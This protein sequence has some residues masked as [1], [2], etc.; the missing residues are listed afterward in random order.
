MMQT[1]LR[2]A[3]L[4]TATAFGAGCSTLGIYDNEF[5]C[6]SSYNGRCISLPG[7]HELAL[8]GNDQPENVSVAKSLNTTDLDETT[9]TLN[10]EESAHAS[11]KESLFKRFDTLLKEPATPV[12]APPQTMRILLLPYKGDSNELYMLR[13]AYFFVDEPRWLLGDSLIAVEEE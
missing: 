6:P 8:Q 2:W 13:Y 10:R 5:T 9:A 12:V 1:F 7:A 11:Y 3:V 4:F